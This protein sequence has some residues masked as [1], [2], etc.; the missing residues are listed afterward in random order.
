MSKAGPRTVVRLLD[1]E[2]V[3]EHSGPL[4]HKVFRVEVNGQEVRIED[5]GIHVTFGPLEP[6]RVTLTLLPDEIHFERS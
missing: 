2:G 1:C 4:P 5:G 6:T 3:E